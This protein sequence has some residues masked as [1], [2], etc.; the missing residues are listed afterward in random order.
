MTCKS[1]GRPII[2][3]PN[4]VHICCTTGMSPSAHILYN[5]LDYACDHIYMFYMSYTKAFDGTVKY[6]SVKTVLKLV[7][8]SQFH[9][10]VKSI[11]KNKKEPRG[12]A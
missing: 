12:L 5:K 7:S 8:Q 2:L 1:S 11:D 4:K 6:T 9:C 10:I 3:S